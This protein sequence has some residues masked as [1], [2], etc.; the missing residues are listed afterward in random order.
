MQTSGVYQITLKNGSDYNLKDFSFKYQDAGFNIPLFAKGAVQSL[1]L[2]DNP[3]LTSTVTQNYK[4]CYR[5]GNLELKNK[6]D[7]SMPPMKI[8]IFN[9]RGQKVQTY[10]TTA[11][12]DKWISPFLHKAS[13]L[14]IARITPQNAAPS[15]FKFTVLK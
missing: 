1:Y 2:A 5:G 10:E 4:M 14:Y 9:L 11:S 8:E 13:G 3:D 6:Y 12:Q 7:L 15:V